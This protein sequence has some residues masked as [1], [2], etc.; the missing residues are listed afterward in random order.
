M[1]T[2]FETGEIPPF[3]TLEEEVAFLRKE[4][5]RRDEAVA[6][7]PH[8][9]SPE[10]RRA[11][12]ARE[13]VR[14][15]SKQPMS[16]T[17]EAARVLPDAMVEG[18]VLNLPPEPHDEIMGEL[19][20]IMNSEGIKN[21][22]AVV[23]KL[24]NPHV[25]DDFHRFLTDYIFEG[26]E[27]PGLGPREALWL[28]LHMTLYE[29]TFPGQRS[30]ERDNFRRTMKELLSV[31]E[32]WYLAMGS[33]RQEG[34]GYFVIELAVAADTEEIAYY[35]SV[36]TASKSVFE[37]Q[38]GAF[39]PE[40]SFKEQHS[41]YNIFIEG[42]T[43]RG[44]YAALKSESIL[45][46][47][48]YD[49][50]DSDPLSSILNA[51][52]KIEKEGVGAALQLVVVPDDYGRTTQFN[53]VLERLKK[54]DRL[55][56]AYKR[57]VGNALGLVAMEFV[58]AIGEAVDQGSYERK[59]RNRDKV[60]EGNLNEM[61]VEEVKKKMRTPLFHAGLRV[62]TSAA[63]VQR[64]DSVL[65]DITSAYKQFDESS[66]NRLI[67]REVPESS[68]RAFLKRYAFRE[69][70]IT[71]EQM[72]LAMGELVAMLHFPSPNFVLPSTF[73]QSRGVSAGAAP[74]IGSEGILLGTNV[75]QNAE[76][77]VH[78]A[79]DDRLRHFY[80]IG[81]TGTGKTTF[82]KN[83]IIQDI[84]RGDG[85]A[86]IDPHG[87]D[88]EDILAAVPRERWDDVIYF[89]P[90][91][92][93]RVF[94][95]NMLEY[96]P[97]H[98]EQKTFVVNELLSIFQKLYG[99]V[100]ESM[101]PAFEQYFRNSCMLV[102]EHPESGATMLDISRVL[103]DARYRNLKLEHSKNVVVNQFWREIATKAGGEA[104]L[105]NI[106]PYITNKFDVFTAN[107]IMRPIVAQE[108]STLNMRTIMDER[109]ILLV[110]LSKGKLG[111]INAN[112]IGLILVGK[113]LMAALSRQSARDL[114]PFYLYIDEFQNV[115]TDSI[116]TILSEARKYKLA[117]TIAH[118][119]IKQLDEKI[120]DAVFGNVGSMAAFRVGAEDAE[121]LEKQM[122]PPFSKNDLM[123][124][125]N[126]QSHLKM[127]AGGKPL[128]PFLLKVS[129]PNP[130]D[131]TN[132]EMLAKISNERYGRPRAE[133]EAEV[134]WRFG[135]K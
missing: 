135:V 18:I 122:N 22:L 134:A 102:M 32:Q 63:T 42:G 37:K 50:F 106:V 29:V 77:P 23:D 6:E 121:F 21:A 104:S 113:F 119:F 62:I 65:D 60:R 19:L 84:E 81:Q 110:N 17:I 64:A 30:S 133:V 2:G 79:P 71:A 92:P 72:T 97:A 54:G 48:Q 127:L 69:E 24:N 96:D 73:R 75:H 4:I 33:L 78:L 38:I 8:T 34:Q 67:W 101:G 39:Y 118:Q 111:D 130:I 58:R 10:K 91:N 93:E 103:A 88:V 66:G 90:G 107:E 70:P 20:G 124:V 123:R 61:H 100:P 114:P 109:K 43:A 74:A 80:T 115:T 31:M 68:L 98:P 117:L 86:F 85:V 1:K 46:L 76:R 120:R 129:A 12:V 14:E 108:R 3:K 7:I 35:V 26:Y 83:M 89:D 45:P 5:V 41:D 105:A 51:F 57:E 52:S 87:A 59:K 126:Y 28:P 36:P 132:A 116:S 82:L 44:A 15:Y 55:H 95:L 47:R 128:P 112:F 49:T 40:A 125:D 16:E 99:K 131:L 56:Q 94:G 25:T 11:G 53:R 27:I 13:V 9:D